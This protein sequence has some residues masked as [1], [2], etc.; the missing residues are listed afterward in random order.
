MPK[1]AHPPRGGSKKSAPSAAQPTSDDGPKIIFT[2]AKDN[3][4]KGKKNN[5]TSTNSAESSKAKGKA[6]GVPETPTEDGPKRPD[7]RTLIGGASWTGKL[8]VNMLSEHCQKQKWDKPEYT[9]MKT[10]H[11]FVS[12]VILKATHPKT[13]ETTTL[14]QIRF[15]KE[16]QAVAGQ[17]TAVEARHFAAAYALFRF[18][19]MKNLHMMMPP[20]YKDLWKGLF[21]D[22]KK[23]DEAQGRGWMYAPDPFAMAK[24]REDEAAAKAKRREEMERSKAKEQASGKGPGNVVIGGSEGSQV[25][26]WTRAPKIDMGRKTRLH[27][28]QLIRK[29]AVWGSSAGGL[30]SKQRS[31]L[32]V[33]VS[34]LGFRAAHVEEAMEVCGSREELLEWLLIHVPEDDLPKWSLPE[35]YTA[36]VSLASSDLKREAIIKRLASSG[37]ATDLCEMALDAGKGDES[38]AST[39][40]QKLLLEEVGDIQSLAEEMARASLGD[41]DS[42]VW[43]DE[44]AVLAS[45]YDDKYNSPNPES[46]SIRIEPE[47]CNRVV[48]TLG[49]RKP[50]GPYPEN[51]PLLSINAELPAYIRLSI[52][53]QALR[54]A[55]DNLLGDQM[56]FSIV[57]WIEHNSAAII[58]QP[59]RLADV[60]SATAAGESK[61]AAASF[62]KFRPQK[63]RPR[64]LDEKATRALSTQMMESWKQKQTTAEQE[65]MLVIRRSLPAWKLQDAIVEAVNGHQVTIISGETGSGK[66]TQS[67]QFILDDM[68][69]R[70][71]GGVT[72]I[73]CTQPRRISALGLADRVAEERCSKVGEE[74]G[75]IIR[76]ESKYKEGQTKITFVTTGVLLRRLQS[77]GGSTKDVVA[78]L[79]DVS[80]VVID[81]V[82]ERS[83]DTDF[84]LVLLRDVLRQRRDLKV[85]LMSATLDADIFAQY[86]SGTGGVARVEIEGRTHPVQDLY[87]DDVVRITGFNGHSEEDDFEEPEVQKQLA[88]TLRG[89]GMRINYDLIAQTVQYIDH[90]LGNQDGGIL[91]FLPG[92][93]EIDRTIQALRNVPNI[94]ALPLHAS[95]LPAEQRRVFPPA[96]KGMRKVIAST[97]V[98][99]TSITI[100]DVVAVIDTGRVK[101]T[102]FDPQSNMVKLQEVWASKAA[103]KQRRGR[104]GRVRAGKCYKLFT[105]AAEAK[106]PER[107]EPEIRR[108]PLEQLCLSVKA[109]GIRDVPAFLAGA[110]TPP[111]RMAVGGAITLLGRMGALD[112]DELTALGRHLSMIPADL[113]CGKLLVYGS[114]FGCLDA[115][116][117]MASILTVR[118]PFV[119]PQAKREE[120]KAARAVFAAGGHGDLVADLRAYDQYTA[121][122]KI[123]PTRDLRRW[124]EDNFLSMATL[125]DITSNRSQYISSLKEIGFLPFGADN[126]T[127]AAMNSNSSSDALLRALIA[128]SFNPQIARVEYPETKFA[129]TSTGAMALDPEAKTIKYFTEDAS[130]SGDGQQQPRNDRVFIHPSSTL[131]DASSFPSNTTF[132]TFFEKISTSKIF[133]RNV[134]PVNA[135][136]VMMFG[137]GVEVD[138]YGRGVVVDGW[139]R[140]KGWARIGVL[141]GRLRKM[142]DRVLEERIERPGLAVG[143]NGEDVDQEIVRVVRKLIELDGLDR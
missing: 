63:R 116:L 33:D 81:E 130:A 8:P 84:L 136:A 143:G 137:G 118:S 30:S 76:G 54:F 65:R 51:L 115:C 3:P 21:T 70:E 27:V 75:Y 103:C 22:L 19:S 34:K 91:I 59:G 17:E 53:K 32:V 92:T 28:E 90:E 4:R 55:K 40:L 41:E 126:A 102:T 67:V 111:D 6:K 100:E 10:D 96:P 142:L 36:G 26:P 44:Q 73:I 127:L 16:H 49:L 113:R 47:G 85:I 138:T 74:V 120:A 128:G 37:Y 89:I 15:P 39:Y 107:P 129:A 68:I 9:M 104:A 5:E 98:A 77:S 1:N 48:I 119:S 56:I 23:E 29:H 114:I 72:N 99:E 71:R 7:T 25:R 80:H 124:C 60:S 42:T 112:G 134:T 43:E 50:I 117:T 140:L 106:M 45:I 24:E 52:L 132:M 135:Y 97:N 69:R 61:T 125:N 62:S 122:R 78:S 57:D 123:L 38:R 66:S 18:S 93:M 88:G 46:C 86:F 94:H 13:R 58:E 79:S 109:M 14:P 20:K 141:V 110:L 35:N 31:A 139:I 83:L 2:N 105:R 101:E 64:P 11:G 131:F 121:N 95:L 82:H 108:V 12:G 87:L 133:L